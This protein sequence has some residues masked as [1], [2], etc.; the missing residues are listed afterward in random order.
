MGIKYLASFLTVDSCLRKNRT[1]RHRTLR[2]NRPVNKD[3]EEEQLGGKIKGECSWCW[4]HQTALQHSEEKEQR[5]WSSYLSSAIQIPI[6]IAD[7]FSSSFSSKVLSFRDSYSTAHSLC[8]KR[9]LNRTWV[10]MFQKFYRTEFGLCCCQK[11]VCT[12]HKRQGKYQKEL[13]K[14]FLVLLNFFVLFKP[15]NFVNISLTF[16]LTCLSTTL[17]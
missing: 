1:F 10:S 3:G 13:Y 12:G 2:K 5:F 16:L 9:I 11:K 7:F 14:V 6:I 15:C 17:Q 8:F 4:A